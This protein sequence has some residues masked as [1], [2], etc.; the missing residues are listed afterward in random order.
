MKR[1]RSRQGLGLACALA[2]GG[3]ALAAFVVDRSFLA[4]HE[5][6]PMATDASHP[7]ELSARWIEVRP[8]VEPSSEPADMHPD[9]RRAPPSPRQIF[10]RA[11]GLQPIEAPAA[12]HEAHVA[13]F[14]EPDFQAAPDAP[15]FWPTRDLQIPPLP[16]SEPDITALKGISASGL[17]IR[18]RIYIDAAGTVANI[19]VLQSVDQDDDAVQRV[20]AMFYD[21]QFLAGKRAGA[22]VPSFIDIEVDMRGLS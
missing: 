22:D 1:E 15:T 17:P 16:R 5:R 21:T 9:G 12:V 6:S 18:L 13:A 19:D 7:F 14:V 20:K 4:A 11:E 3:H 2:L 10:P 8:P